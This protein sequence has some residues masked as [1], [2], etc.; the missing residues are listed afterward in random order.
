LLFK[1][2]IAAAKVV[3][4][5]ARLKPKLGASALVEQ[6]SERAAKSLIDQ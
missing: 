2:S 1:P 4:Q 3:A 5:F 6:L